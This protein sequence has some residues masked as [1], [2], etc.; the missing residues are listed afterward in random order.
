MEKRRGQGCLPISSGWRKMG[1]TGEGEMG[2]GKGL[3]FARFMQALVGN[4]TVREP[5]GGML[6]FCMVYYAGWI[7]MSCRRMVMAMK[8]MMMMKNFLASLFKA[9]SI[10]RRPSVTSGREAKADRPGESIRVIFSPLS[11]SLSFALLRVP[12]AS[13]SGQLLQKSRPETAK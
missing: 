11:S 3:K 8:V 6:E 4:G 2:L 5:G 13:P 7:H 12:S 9:A 1:H 10:P